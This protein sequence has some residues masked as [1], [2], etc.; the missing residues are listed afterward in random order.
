MRRLTCA[1]GSCRNPAVYRDSQGATQHFLPLCQYLIS[2]VFT[3]DSSVTAILRKLKQQS[4]ESVEDK[5]PK[6]LKALREVSAAAISR[7]I[8]ALLS[9]TLMAHPRFCRIM[10]FRFCRR[11]L[12]P[13][14]KRVFVFFVARRLLSGAALGLSE[15]GQ[16]FIYHQTCLYVLFLVQNVKHSSVSHSAFVVPD[17]SIGHL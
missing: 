2:C 13:F 16:V 7:S 15:L 9:H 8:T 17:T 14:I 5:R 4:R 12:K 3:L 6:L 1:N 10:M 11:L